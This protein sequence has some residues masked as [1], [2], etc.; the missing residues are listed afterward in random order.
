MYSSGRTA[1]ERYSKKQRIYSAS[2]GEPIGSPGNFLTF[3]DRRGDP[4]VIP[5]GG[6]LSLEHE[7]GRVRLLVLVGV[8]DEPVGRVVNS[9]Y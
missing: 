7:V 6:V 2:A 8:P 3:L 5:E 1:T 9:N 4:L